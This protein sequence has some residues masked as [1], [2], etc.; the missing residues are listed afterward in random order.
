MLQAAIIVLREG[1]EAFLIVAL[2]LSYLEKR[3]A[4]WLRAAVY[5]GVVV[6]VIASLAA[7]YALREGVHQSLWEGILG[8]ATVILVGTLVIQMWRWGPQ[9]KGDV[10]TKLFEFSSR[11]SRRAALWG[12]FLFTVLMITREG[13]EMVVMLFQVRDPRFVSGF[14]LGFSGAVALAWAWNRFSYLIDL[15]RFFEV[16]G[17]FLLLFLVQVAITSVHEFSEAGVLPYSEAVHVATERFS[18][19]GLYGKWFSLGIVVI[20]GIWLCLSWLGELFSQRKIRYN[21]WPYGEGTSSRT[22]GPPSEQTP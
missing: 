11:S 2:I 4:H 3:Q 19:V 10:E 7:G 20:C 21:I 22:Q 15:K 14:V 8:I 13:M 12:V 16:T 6:S 5:W 17:I 1:F 9:L 18:P